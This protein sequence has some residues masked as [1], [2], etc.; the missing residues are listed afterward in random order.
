MSRFSELESAEVLM[1]AEGD[2][3]YNIE[4]CAQ[5][6]LSLC[7]HHVS[8]ILLLSP[9]LHCDINPIFLSFQTYQ[10]LHYAQLYESSVSS[11]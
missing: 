10:N 9:M 2:V 1:E 4:S 7:P 11:L 6:T 3:C 5:I 8:S